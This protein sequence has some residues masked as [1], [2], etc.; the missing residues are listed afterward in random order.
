M[1]LQEK[2]L[3]RFLSKIKINKN[4]CWEWQG[5]CCACGYGQVK[6]RRLHKTVLSAHRVSYE[7]FKGKI[8]KNLYVCHSC[9]N[10][11]C[12]NPAHLFIGTH[13]ENMNDMK[14]K[15]RAKSISRKGVKNPS[16]KLT[17]EDVRNIMKMLPL[18]NNKEIAE[19]FNVTH[20]MIS[21]IRCGASWTHITGFTENTFNKYGSITKKAECSSEAEH[22]VWDREGEISTFSTP[23]KL[24]L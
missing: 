2:E 1:L 15:G 5:A 6:I 20:S 9:D 14:K 10:R 16:S 24:S 17:E 8:P 22:S 19:L 13:Q 4:E 21:S 7:H 12:V 11:K 23:T 18:K 3:A